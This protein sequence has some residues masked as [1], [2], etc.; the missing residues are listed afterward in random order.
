MYVYINI[1]VIDVI[2]PYT[3]I[4]KSSTVSVSGR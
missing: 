3:Y 2:H 4:Y 1:K